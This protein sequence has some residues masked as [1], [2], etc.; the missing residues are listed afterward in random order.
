MAKKRGRKTVGDCSRVSGC[1][2]DEQLP[3]G[4]EGRGARLADAS[5]CCFHARCRNN[6][7]DFVAGR[8][9]EEI[10]TWCYPLIAFQQLTNLPCHAMFAGLTVGQVKVV[11]A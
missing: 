2:S 4:P 9:R 3:P 7:V 8:T 10:K 6:I 11:V 5:S 1:R